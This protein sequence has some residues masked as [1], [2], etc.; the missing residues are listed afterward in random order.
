MSSSAIVDFMRAEKERGKA[1][2]YSTHYMEEAELLCDRILMLA[3]GRVTAEGTLQEIYA[4]TETTNLRD[5]FKKLIP[6]GKEEM[7]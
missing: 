3:H 2:L 1:V 7:S 6:A 5:A 4:Q